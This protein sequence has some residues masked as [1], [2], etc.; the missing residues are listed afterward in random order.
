MS[1]V[2]NKIICEGENNYNNMQNL[3]DGCFFGI[4]V[5][6]YNRDSC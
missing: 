1:Y 4:A 6:T 5:S 3:H 2:G